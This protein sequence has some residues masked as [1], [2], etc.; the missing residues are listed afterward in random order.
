MEWRL[1]QTAQGN[2]KSLLIVACLAVASYLIYIFGSYPEIIPISLYLFSYLILRS[3]GLCAISTKY[4]THNIYISILYT[5]IAF[6][7]FYRFDAHN[8]PLLN[9]LYFL[10]G[11]GLYVPLSLEVALG[12]YRRRR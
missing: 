5:I 9:F 10:L 6:Y 11:I 2:I 3:N 1:S 4:Q 8:Y 12:F 7:G